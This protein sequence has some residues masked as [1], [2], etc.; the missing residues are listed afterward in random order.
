MNTNERKA[1][2]AFLSDENKTIEDVASAADLS[3]RTIY[4]YLKDPTFKAELKQRQGFIVDRATAR[5]ARLAEKA[6]DGLE[7]VLDDPNQDGAANK[8]L[9]AKDVLSLLDTFTNRDLDDR[10]SA[11]E[12]AVF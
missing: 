12:D 4:R 3:P 11:L 8:R 5:L 7:S 1:L 6:V 2:S 9:A 10:I